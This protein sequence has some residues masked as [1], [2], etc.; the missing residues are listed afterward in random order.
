[1]RPVAAL[2]VIFFVVVSCA[3]SN[4]D[5]KKE[6]A[7]NKLIGQV[8]QFRK[9]HDRL[10]ES[11]AEM[12]IQQDESGPVFYQKQ[13]ANHYIVWYGTGVGES[14]VYDSDVGHWNDH[15]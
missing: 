1:M 14:M 15:D 10:P 13:S 9:Q 11:A 7:G 2:I 4:R 6:A 5:A 8:E 3:C 12:G